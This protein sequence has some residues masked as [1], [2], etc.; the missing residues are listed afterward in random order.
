M[1]TDPTAPKARSFLDTLT[2]L[3]YGECVE[4]LTQ[5]MHQLLCAVNRT[6]RAG[7]LT[8]K[9]HVKPVDKGPSVERIEMRDDIKLNMPKPERGATFLFLDGA[10]NPSTQDP[11]QP[12]LELRAVPAEKPAREV[13]NG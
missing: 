12:Q 10:N 7:S 6:G 13:S 2:K 5:E 3:R 4:N 9:I 11:R 1:N 8:L